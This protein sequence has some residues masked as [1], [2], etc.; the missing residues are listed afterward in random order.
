MI[1]KLIMS[2]IYIQIDDELTTQHIQFKINIM[3]ARVE[4]LS[5]NT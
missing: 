1:T 2:Q 5:N 4:D 3:F